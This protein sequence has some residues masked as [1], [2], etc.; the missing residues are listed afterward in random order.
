ML[1]IPQTSCYFFAE[2]IIRQV[3]RGPEALSWSKPLLP[4]RSQKIRVPIQMVE[5]KWEL[6]IGGQALFAEGTKADLIVDRRSIRDPALLQIFETDNAYKILEEETNLLICL[7]KREGY[8][9]QESLH[10][11]KRKKST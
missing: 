3:A 4:D 9:P 8:P 2:N 7:R 11:L 5:G 10:F 6:K 1:P